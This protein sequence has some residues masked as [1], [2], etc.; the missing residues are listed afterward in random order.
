MILEESHARYTGRLKFF[1][2]NKNYG[3]IIMDDDGSD[4]FVHYDDLSKAGIGKDLLKTAKAGAVIKL[5]FTC[6]KYLGKYDKSRKATDIELLNS[7]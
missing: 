1:D 6:M 3:F 7:K 5:A 2:E 4:I